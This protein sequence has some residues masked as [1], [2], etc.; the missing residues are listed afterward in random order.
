MRCRTKG[1]FFSLVT[2]SGMIGSSAIFV[3]QLVV[4]DSNCAVT[5]TTVVG[6]PGDQLEMSQRLSN[7]T[8]IDPPLSIDYEIIEDDR[9][10]RILRV[11]SLI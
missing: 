6:E 9:K 10:V 4:S 2:F 8:E 1:L 11:W 7:R 5:P 3:V